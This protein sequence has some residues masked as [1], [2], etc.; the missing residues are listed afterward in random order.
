MG[1]E[2]YRVDRIANTE[3]RRKS[4]I[5]VG[6]EDKDFHP[7]DVDNVATRTSVDC[8]D[9]AVIEDVVFCT[10]CAGDLTRR[11]VSQAADKNASI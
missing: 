7:D 4:L 3:T 11:Y 6:R 1:N 9:V 5:I 8:Q 2:G 10:K